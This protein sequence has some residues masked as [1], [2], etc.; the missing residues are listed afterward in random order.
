[1]LVF[2][3]SIDQNKITNRVKSK[4]KRP[5]AKP[6]FNATNCF[7]KYSFKPTQTKNLSINEICK[8]FICFYLPIITARGKETGKSNINAN[9]EALFY[10]PRPFTTPR[11]IIYVP[12]KEINAIKTGI[13]SAISNL[14]FFILSK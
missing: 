10:S 7:L 13:H 9:I 3:Q 11:R 14:E 4:K 1:M 6:K 8:R 12:D 2:Y 5:S